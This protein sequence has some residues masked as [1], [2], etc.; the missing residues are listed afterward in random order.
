MAVNLLQSVPKL[1][2]RENYSDW[3]FAVSNM[4]VLDD[5]Q[6]CINGSITDVVKDGK[7][8][9]KIILTIDTSLYVHIKDARTTVDV[10]T[11]LKRL[12]DDT[13]FSRRIG[14]LRALISIRLDDCESMESY[15]TKMIET[16][17]KLNGTGFQIDDRWIG[18]LLLAGLPEKYA[19]MIMA[20][21]HSG[22]EVTV[23]CIK[24]KLLDMEPV[25]KAGN[26]FIGRTYTHKWKSKPQVGNNASSSD[27]SVNNS[28]LKHVKCF[29][30]HQKGHYKNNCPVKM[31]T[32]GEK[33]PNAFSTVFM[34]GQYDKCDWYVDSGASVHLT[35]QEDFVNNVSNSGNLKEIVTAN[36]QRLDVKCMG[37]VQITTVVD[38][39]C[40]D[41]IITNAMCVPDLMTNLLSVSQLIKNGNTVE[42]EEKGCKIYNKDKALVAVADLINNVYKLRIKDESKC[43]LTTTKV[44]KDIWHRR[45]GHINNKDLSKMQA[46]IVDGMH[47][48]GETTL[49]EK[50]IICCEGKQT[51]LPFKHK[52]TRANSVLEV[53]HADV[54]GPMENISIGGSKYFLLFE[55]D[56]SRMTF[57]YFLKN[58][59]DVFECFKNFKSLVENQKE[60]KIKCLR[61]DNG[62]EFCGN[63][64][65]KF[66][67]SNGI[68]HQTTNAHTPEQ[69]GML[70]RM[71]RSI[72]EKAKCLLFDAKLNIKFWA[73]AVNTS[74]YLKNRSIAAGLS[75]K[76]PFE[77]WYN[78]K[79]DLS[80][81]RVFGSTAM[82]H[83]PKANRTKWQK[84]ST[85][86]ILMGFGEST[87]GYRV[88]NPENGSIISSRDVIIIEK[89]NEEINII[90]KSDS[91][92][93][94]T[95]NEIRIESEINE[96]NLPQTDEEEMSNP[97]DNDSDYVPD[98]AQEVQDSV[99]ENQM[100]LRRSQREAKP[101]IFN[102]YVTY[103][104]PVS[105]IKQENSPN[106]VVEALSQPDRELWKQAIMQE[107]RSFE[108]NDAWEI[109]DIPE[110]GTIVQCK[111][112]FK[113]KFDNENKVKYRARLV[114]KGF[115]QQPGIDFD[116]TFAPVVRHSTLRL[117]FALSV[118][119]DLDIIHLD[120]PTA[121]L[122]GLLDE[123]VYMM[124][125]ESFEISN[126]KVLKL[127]KA[128]YGLRQS[129]RNW[130]RRVEDCLLSLDYK[131]S[132]L[133]QCLFMKIKNNYKTFIA[134][135]VDDFFVFS[136]DENEVNYLNDK[137]SFEFKVKNLGKVKQCLGMRV[138]VDKQKG[139]I[140]LDQEQYVDC[141]LNKFQMIDCKDVSTPIETKLTIEKGSNCDKSIPF[142][143]LI[144]SLMYLAVLTRPD[145]AF[146]VSY[147]SQ[148]NNCYNDTHWQYAKR[149]LRYLHK[150][151]SYGLCFVKDS[152]ELEGFVDSDWGSSSFDRKSY[153][154]FCFKLSSSVISWKSQ[155][156]KTVALS[157][158]EAEYVAISEAC[159]EAIYLRNLVFELTNELH[160]LT[161]FNDNQ[162]A[163]KLCLSHNLHEK[164]KHI[165]VRHHFV[166]EAV[167]NGWIRT[168]YLSTSEMPA[169]ILTKGLPPVKHYKFL[170]ALGISNIL[171]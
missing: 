73:E 139:M 93:D 23:D 170:N 104:C 75:D 99:Q 159:K 56:Y 85:K 17:Q 95:E 57:V 161:L 119:L 145:I 111:W 106:T 148:F 86:M 87:K 63:E 72:V 25:G 129:S 89:G 128:I 101:H 70:E 38:K 6:G 27:V 58:K 2:G 127:K 158:T 98:N 151:K 68:V 52:G 41:I 18:S 147:L 121:F 134:L 122:N 107:L 150:T 15:V 81:I 153:S 12:F 34:T 77:M 7:A 140:T 44:S 102:D 112:V 92:G 46:G 126:N 114:A 61:T 168:Q 37:N 169:D 71:N 115:A 155:K 3:S 50:C 143:Q 108:D 16:A 74:V 97:D 79:P 91:V 130:Y 120:V 164:S 42:F 80:H 54:C 8:K 137:L 33:S 135:Y 21:E 47:V 59:S 65:E 141:L 138:N 26:A 110:S 78:R 94:S 103:L 84:K 82:V 22:I 24:M 156:Q 149:I 5:L 152:T 163:Q 123:E 142:Q 13:G 154:G 31:E 19:P 132:N 4:L 90:I 118:K 32:K 76:T 162:S 11:Q 83:V 36:N 109:V 66:L 146:S 48:K 10:W 124:P 117:L 1:K 14:L 29:R 45:L 165:D 62:G 53:I 60:R 35:V 157:S 167:D 144:G 131:K 166:K 43:F 100:P 55:D 28:N 64:M 160:C 116:E 105:E 30:C 9:A 88:F 39:S 136:N 69:N 20:I 96:T 49:V 40:Y 133:E 51:R 125:P 67:R 113:K 171:I